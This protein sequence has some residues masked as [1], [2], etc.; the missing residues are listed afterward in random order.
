MTE[1]ELVAALKA[2]AKRLGVNEAM[3]ANP[4][5]ALEAM[6]REAYRQF[7]KRSN[8]RERFARIAPP[9]EVNNG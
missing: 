3:A 6:G 9:D 8:A 5:L 2:I 4:A 1:Q 7:N